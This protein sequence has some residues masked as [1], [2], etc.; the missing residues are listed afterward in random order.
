MLDAESKLD[1]LIKSW[2]KLDLYNSD[3]G[4]IKDLSSIT[5]ICEALKDEKFETLNKSVQA[6]NLWRYLAATAINLT[7]EEQ[8]LAQVACEKVW[9][10]STG[11]DQSKIG[12]ER[13]KIIRDCISHC[14]LINAVFSKGQAKSL[15]LEAAE[16]CREISKTATQRWLNFNLAA[17]RNIES[18][19]TLVESAKRLISHCSPAEWS[20]LQWIIVQDLLDQNLYK[21][22]LKQLDKA[23]AK[24]G[25]NED[26][27]L[28]QRQKIICDAHLDVNPTFDIQKM[29][30][31]TTQMNYWHIYSQILLQRNQLQGA[32]EAL[33]QAVA[34]CSKVGLILSPLK[35]LKLSTYLP[36]NEC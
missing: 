18:R 2:L 20:R 17:S 5:E 30:D 31:L 27:K 24:K 25:L 13:T 10:L 4:P 34:M 16:N 28:L 6:V 14:Q 36:T 19:R 22:A 26:K 21:E 12:P 29:G 1:I 8:L 7:S 32:I 33:S 35:V 11:L 15:Y 9:L 23:L 3:L